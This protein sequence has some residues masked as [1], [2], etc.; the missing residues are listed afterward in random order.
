MSSAC[1]SRRKGEP[2]PQPEPGVGFRGKDRAQGTRRPPDPSSLPPGPGSETPLLAP[3][4]R[5]VTAGSPP[6]DQCAAGRQQ[7]PGQPSSPLAHEQEDL[8]DPAGGSILCCLQ[9]GGKAKGP[10]EPQGFRGRGKSRSPGAWA[11]AP[12][13]FQQ[14]LLVTAGQRP[15]RGLISP[16]TLR[17]CRGCLIP[18]GF[19]ASLL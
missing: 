14:V 11:C 9:E 19:L 5:V 6:G 2:E 3:V 7:V 4:R 10:A 17:I 13:A 16:C 12:S 1:L 8:R 18:A 15:F